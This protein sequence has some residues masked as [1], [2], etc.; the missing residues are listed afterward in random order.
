[1]LHIGP[2]VF[3]VAG[4]SKGL[5]LEVAV[6][7]RRKG[8]GAWRTGARGKEGERLACVNLNRKKMSSAETPPSFTPPKES[9]GILDGW[10]FVLLSICSKIC[11]LPR[12]RRLRCSGGEISGRE[13]FRS[14]E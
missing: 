13:I 1:M 11:C 8:K 14:L 7:E 9:L 5:L 4:A 3:E 2:G 6:M 12:R 10:V